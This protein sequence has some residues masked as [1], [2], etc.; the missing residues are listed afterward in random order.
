[1]SNHHPMSLPLALTA[2]QRTLYSALMGSCKSKN[3]LS[4][5]L[6]PLKLIPEPTQK[7][8]AL[9]CLIPGMKTVFSLFVLCGFFFFS[10]FKGWKLQISRFQGKLVVL[11]FKLSLRC[12][13]LQT[14]VNFKHKQNKCIIDN[15]YK[16]T[17][18]HC[19]FSPI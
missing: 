11:F 6:Q 10:S 14:K 17:T 8:K 1:M 7:D 16:T 5:P 4:C 2:K 18:I 15:S 13:V 19:K 12:S 9:E 3:S